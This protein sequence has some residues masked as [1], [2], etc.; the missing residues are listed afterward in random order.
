MYKPAPRVYLGAVEMLG[1][2]AGE[3]ALVAAHLGDLQAARGCGLRTVYVEREGEEAWG[4]EEVERARG[5]GWV[6]LWVGVGEGEEGGL[7]EVVRWVGGAGAG[8]G[9][10]DEGGGHGGKYGEGEDGGGSGEIDR[11][12]PVCLRQD[13]ET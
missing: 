12:S 13:L 2:K 6:D 9:D 11:A 10:G 8:R 5:E 3:C 1:L 7:G 4:V